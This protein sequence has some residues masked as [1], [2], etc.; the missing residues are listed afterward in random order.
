MSIRLGTLVMLIFISALPAMVAQERTYTLQR[1][2]TIYSI[3]RSHGVNPDD[4]M[5]LNGIED[6]RKIQAGQ[7]IR[8]PDA[9]SGANTQRYLD[10]QAVRGDSLWALARR[11]GTTMEEI[12]RANNL[13]AEYML[14]EGDVL[15]I[16]QGSAIP[17]SDPP[18]V[19][20]AVI[21]SSASTPPEPP[22]ASTGIRVDDSP[23][24]AV[25]GVIDSSI[26]WP[27][28]AKEIMYLTGKLY[29]VVLLG[30]R[31]E[32]V[33]SLTHGTVVSAGPYRGFGRVAIVQM[34]GGYLYVYGGC[35]S[36]TVREGDSVFPGT[37]LGKLGIDG[38][39]SKPQ[40]F[41]MVYFSNVPL[42]PA[43]APRT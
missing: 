3:A 8:I 27:I 2:D 39:S 40:L 43:L 9:A 31:S 16:P 36:L 41:F 35:E 1:G 12:R 5:R 25:T 37:E 17:Q 22:R 38:V 14:R 23:R 26:R 7:T 21:P 11:F 24:S 18:P 10:Y 29:G 6:P 28:Q 4:I 30:E 19:Q 33:L 32:S 42:D 20:S 13:S 15:R 34:T